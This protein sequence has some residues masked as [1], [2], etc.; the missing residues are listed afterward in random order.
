[1]GELVGVW[2][3]WDGGN[4]LRIA[5]YGYGSFAASSSAWYP[6]YPGAVHVAAWGF[7]G[8][9]AVAGVCTAL[10]AALAAFAL[11]YRLAES[12]LG[13]SGARRAV[14]YL[15][16]FPM[17]FY[18]QAA[19]GESLYLA[20]ALATFV[21]AERGRFAWAATA[22]GAALLARPA[23]VALI[24]ALAVTAWRAPRRWEALRALAIVPA[25]FTIFPLV[26]W[27]QIGRP[28]AFIHAE[29]EST[30][31]RYVSAAGPFGG[32][33]Q[34]ARAGWAA[35]EQLASGS[36]THRY[37]TDVHLADVDPIPVA[38]Q[39]LQELCFCAFFVA[40]AVVIWRRLPLE[41]SLFT[42][43]SLAMP[44]AAPT[45]SSPLLSLPRFGLVVFPI[46]LALADLGRNRWVHGAVLVVFPLLTVWAS[47]Y[48]GRG[49]WIA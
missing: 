20:L 31:H 2:A 19:Y 43:V 14:L 21:L 39:H 30:G 33:W 41:Y 22:A 1:V 11:L 44:L 3:Q 42:L 36:H 37:W 17:S 27:R 8:H 6:L 25:L 34:G 13:R 35:V 45:T 26:L 24:P 47:V 10:L 12:R 48:W 46:Y 40:M 18:L 23:G 7:G 15:A 16:L 9:Y 4:L 28:W 38:I 49:S 29:T 5:R 32:L